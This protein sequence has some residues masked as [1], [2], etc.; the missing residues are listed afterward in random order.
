MRLLTIHGRESSAWCVALQFVS[1][2]DCTMAELRVAVVGPGAIG[3]VVAAALHEQGITPMLCGR[4]SA[5][6]VRLIADGR[7]ETVPGPV[8]TDPT[9]VAGMAD[10]V[11]PAVKATQIAQVAGWLRAL[12][13][14]GTVICV[15]QNGLE[16][17]EL[18]APFAPEACVVPAVVWFPAT[19][20]SSGVIRLLGA[21]RITIPDVVGADTVGTALDG[22]RCAVDISPDF[23]AQAWRKLLQNA[24]AGIMAIT[25]RRAGVFARE[26]IGTLALAYLRECRT[27]AKAA[28]VSLDGDLPEQILTAFRSSPPD[29]GTSILA[30][31]ELGR[32]LEWDVRNGVVQRTAR[33]HG[34]PTPISDVLVPLLA[35]TSD[36]PG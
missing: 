29:G 18:V 17:T 33:R 22:S 19:R 32:P 13:R 2:K 35:A 28:G 11:F 15:L 31:R 6:S 4:T 12:V 26:D 10:L 34:V 16:Q 14:P 8:H 7:L 24:A 5:A 23:E 3:T 1:V 36:G 21:A 30:D 9:S 25:G 27:V 20:E